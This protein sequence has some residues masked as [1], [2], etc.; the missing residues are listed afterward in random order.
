LPD[1]PGQ[2]VHEA[3]IRLYGLDELRELM[4]AAGFEETGVYGTYHAEPFAGHHRQLL[5]VGRKV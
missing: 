3:S 5:Y 4:R 2:V 1:D